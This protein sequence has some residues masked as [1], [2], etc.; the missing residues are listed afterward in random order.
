VL[1]VRQ[2]NSPGTFDP[3]M[4]GRTSMRTNKA[5]AIGM[6]CLWVVGG[7]ISAAAA[8]DRSAATQPAAAAAGAATKP[9][10]AATPTTKPAMMTF[11]VTAE[12]TTNTA[13]PA[14]LSATQK[15]QLDAIIAKLDAATAPAA[16]TK[17]AATTAL[18]PAE[19][20]PAGEPAP[21]VKT[22]E[23]TPATKAV[24]PAASPA[25][26]AKAVEP[27]P[28]TKAAEAPKLPAKKLDAFVHGKNI[29]TAIDQDV[30][31]ELKGSTATQWEMLKLDGASLQQ[32]GKIEFKP[33][34]EG[35]KDGVY[36]ATFKGVKEGKTTVQ[37]QLLIEAGKPAKM[38]IKFTVTVA[39][40][41]A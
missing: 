34:A 38:E 28:T 29:T 11:V 18:S 39:A 23:P 15:A 16:E 5:F 20:K 40:S 25:P 17:P 32:V 22:G 24:E 26:V 12:P 2:V 9:A 7:V 31:L 14:S 41:G 3:A 27:A 8:Q 36:T 10:L 21:V 19:T 37:L 33:T 13:P 6:V 35:A 30:V 4:K 1:G